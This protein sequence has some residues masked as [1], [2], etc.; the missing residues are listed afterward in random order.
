MKVLVTGSGGLVGQALLKELRANGHDVTR[1]VRRAAVAADERSWDPLKGEIDQAALAVEGVVHLA[2]EG[3]AEGRWTEAK[4]KRIRDSRVDG[5]RLLCEAIAR[6]PEAPRVLVAASAI[7]FYGDG[8]DSRLGESA[9]SGTGFLP[10]VCREWEAATAA[11]GEA[12]TRIVNLRLGVILSPEGGALARML[13]PFRLGVGGRLGDGQQWMSWVSLDDVIGAIS[14][15]LSADDLSGPVNGVAPHPVTNAEF[16]RT[17]GRVLSRPTVFPMPGFAARLAFGQM[18]DDLL[19]A[20]LRVEP[21][22]LMENGFQF[23]Q[24]ELETALRQML[25]RPAA[26]AA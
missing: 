8:G 5:T 20:S 7:G 18:A 10:D 3:I 2:G 4:K 1:L 22:A 23:Q 25:D 14:H 21:K 12:G 6:S 24:P 16:T 26:G 15:G 11:A 19:L 17:L 13:T 9:D